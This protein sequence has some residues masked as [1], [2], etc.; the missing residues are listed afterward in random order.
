MGSSYAKLWN[1]LLPARKARLLQDHTP[2]NTDN[3]FNMSSSYIHQTK[4][5]RQTTDLRYLTNSH[6]INAQTKRGQDLDGA[7]FY[8]TLERFLGCK[9]GTCCR[10]AR[11]KTVTLCSTSPGTGFDVLN[12]TEKPLLAGLHADEILR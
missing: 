4:Q 11:H 12:V 9:K 6:F 3:M 8:K 2:H 1:A 5:V 7:V 10:T